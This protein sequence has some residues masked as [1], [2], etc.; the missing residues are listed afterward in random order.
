MAKFSTGN[1]PRTM[2]VFDRDL[3]LPLPRRRLRVS[4]KLAKLREFLQKDGSFCISCI[5][6]SDLRLID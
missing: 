2:H 5:I 6:S 3:L 4:S 1:P